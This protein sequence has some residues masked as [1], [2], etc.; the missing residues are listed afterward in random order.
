M[1]YCLLATFCVATLITWGFAIDVRVH[2]G[3]TPNAGQPPCH[4]WSQW[5]SIRFRSLICAYAPW[6]IHVDERAKSRKI[7]P[8]ENV[9]LLFVSRVPV[10][11]A[12][13]P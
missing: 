10:T 6:G 8:P 9:S 2:N 4:E 7:Y 12:L 3:T 13:A 5:G 11:R 1:L